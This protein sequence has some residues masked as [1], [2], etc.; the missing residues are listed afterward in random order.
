MIARALA[1]L[2]AIAIENAFAWSVFD[3]EESILPRAKVDHSGHDCIK[4][5]HE[6]RNPLMN[7]VAI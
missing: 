2:G 6:I 4:I 5:A 1:D 3:S 7:S